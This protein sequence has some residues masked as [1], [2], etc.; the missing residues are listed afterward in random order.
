MLQTELIFL[1]VFGWN[2][3]PVTIDVA[4]K[5]IPRLLTSFFKRG[6]RTGGGNN[7]TKCEE[8]F[9]ALTDAKCFS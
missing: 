7:M 3:T 4:S 9:H 1:Y 5:K 6:Q 2:F 8:R